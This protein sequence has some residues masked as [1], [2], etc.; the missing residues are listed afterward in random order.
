MSS[1][2]KRASDTSASGS[3]AKQK[4]SRCACG[5]VTCANAARH[6]QA[7]PPRVLTVYEAIGRGMDNHDALPPTVYE[8]FSMLLFVRVHACARSL[9]A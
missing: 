1:G 3:P 5:I 4:V 8:N 7:P 2:A 9:V 6:D